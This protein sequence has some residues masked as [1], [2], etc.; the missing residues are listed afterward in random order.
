MRVLCSHE[1][2]GFSNC[3]TRLLWTRV[4]GGISR[5]LEQTGPVARARLARAVAGGADWLDAA[6]DQLNL[7]RSAVESLAGANPALVARVMGGPRRGP[8]A[9]DYAVAVAVGV[10]ADVLI[11]AAGAARGSQQYTGLMF[12]LEGLLLGAA[13]GARLGLVASLAPL[14]AIGLLVGSSVA[15]GSEHCS[16]ECSQQAVDYLFVALLVGSAAGIAGLLRDRYFPR[17]A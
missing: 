5:A 11:V 14:A 4:Q 8:P 1:L 15:V 7:G 12:M 6:L 9:R 16:P 2:D 17:A 13:M 3:A 10:I